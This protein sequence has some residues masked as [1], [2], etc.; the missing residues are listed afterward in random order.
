MEVTISCVFEVLP[1]LKETRI[2][3]H[4]SFATLFFVHFLAGLLFCLNSGTYWV[5]LFNSNAGSW[6]ILL[7]G[8]F[9][10]ISVSWL[11]GMNN[12]RRDVRCMLGEKFTGKAFYIW[13]ALWGLISPVII[14]VSHKILAKNKLFIEIVDIFLLFQVI[15]V[16]S[17]T[18]ITEQTLGDYKFPYWAFIFGQLLTASIMLGIFLWPVYA[19]V[20]A[21]FYKKRSLKSLFLPDFEAFKPASD[22]AKLIVANSRN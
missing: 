9:E 20:D 6:A 14:F 8:C 21:K 12:I 7:V 15:F 22:S 11:Y 1:R 17:L 19:L 10:L 13:Y 4:A 3:R 18:Q 5:E 2:K 16:I